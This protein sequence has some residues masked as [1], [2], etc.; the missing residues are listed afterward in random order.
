MPRPNGADKTAAHEVYRLVFTA[1]ACPLDE[2]GAIVS[3]ADVAGQ[4][5]QVM[6]N[7]S[8]ALHAAGADLLDVVKTAVYVARGRK[9]DLL[10]AWEVVSRHFADHDVPSTLLG[11]TAL[12]CADQLVEV[13][14]IQ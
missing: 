14:A 1:G 7:L 8:F 6:V 12:G 2:L 4:A 9:E 11:V 13:E 3:F 5:D 10:S